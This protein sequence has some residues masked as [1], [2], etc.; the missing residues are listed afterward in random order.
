MPG[1]VFLDGEQVTLRPVTEA[2]HAFLRR[3]WNHPEVRPGFG[4]ASPWTAG[5]V[6]DYV[7]EFSDG[8]DKEIFLICADDEP[9]GEAFLFALNEQ[10]G[11]V[12]LGYWVIPE[13][14]G[15]GY[16]SETVD[17]LVEYCFAERRL[18]KIDA[19]VLAFNDGSRRVLEKAGFEPEGCRRDEFYV[20]GEYVDAD[21]YGLVADDWRDGA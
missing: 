16:A 20:D 9:V 11:T 4:A 13:H 5:D 15:N 6:A 17:L 12:E 1:P 14:Q 3:G 8:D 2:D 21:L 19:R 7:E 18:H 10:R